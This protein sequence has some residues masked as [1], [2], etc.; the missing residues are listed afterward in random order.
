MT[1]K[2][3]NSRTPQL[4]ELLLAAVDRGLAEVH[5]CMPG[6]VE[7]YDPKTQTA[8]ILPALKQPFV[9]VDGGEGL[10]EL[11]VLPDVPIGFPRGGKY[12]MSLPLEAGDDVLLMFSE[13]SI[14]K[15]YAGD[16]KKV[17][18]PVDFRRFDLSDAFAIP[19]GYPLSRAIGDAIAKGLVMGKEGG[20]QIRFTDDAVEVVSGAAEA[21]DDFVAMAAKVKAELDAIQTWVDSH[22]HITTATVGATPTPGVISPAS[23]SLGPR[24]D[25]A[26]GNLKAGN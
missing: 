19:G 21:A 1:R 22:I 13:N 4:A 7:S 16:G 20:L 6:I 14:D 26:S 11:P 18:D 23:P 17:V 9:D 8:N 5:T 10:D 3:G 12:F 15:W 2:L 25:V 24:G